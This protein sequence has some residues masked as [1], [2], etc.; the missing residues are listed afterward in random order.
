V[1][2]QHGDSL[3]A[4]GKSPGAQLLEKD[5][6]LTADVAA[7]SDAGR[8]LR[9]TAEDALERMGLGRPG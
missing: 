5:V 6:A 8:F 4:W 9:R 2:A 3:E 7:D 1:F